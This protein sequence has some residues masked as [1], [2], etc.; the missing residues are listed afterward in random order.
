[1]ENV[2]IACSR[3]LSKCL[4]FVAWSLKCHSGIMSAPKTVETCIE[5]PTG[6]TKPLLCEYSFGTG[7]TGSNSDCTF[8]GKGTHD[9]IMNAGECIKQIPTETAPGDTI[10]CFCNTDLCNGECTASNCKPAVAK[11]HLDAN[12]TADPNGRM[13]E[14]C[15]S[16]CKKSDAKSKIASSI[17]ILAT[18]AI[19]GFLILNM[20]M[21]LM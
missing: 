17:M 3:F 5:R 2:C 7:I 6:D 14:K 21:I 13:F 1:M 11:L 15:T 12:L 8:G 19:I 9:F 10:Y 16:T 18:Q 20:K 4:S